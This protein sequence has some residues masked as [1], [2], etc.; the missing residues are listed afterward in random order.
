MLTV[1]ATRQ[2]ESDH[3]MYCICIHAKLSMIYT[4]R[5]SLIILATIPAGLTVLAIQTRLML[6]VQSPRQVV[7]DCRVKSDLANYTPSSV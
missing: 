2:V 4:P 5:L 1:Q 6:T 7:S 3:S